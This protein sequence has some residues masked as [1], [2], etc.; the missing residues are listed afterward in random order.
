MVPEADNYGGH[1][2]A[3][4]A[5]MTNLEK[6]FHGNVEQKDANERKRVAAFQ[7][8]MQ[9]KSDEWDQRTNMRKA[10]LQALTTAID[11]VSKR[12]AEQAGK[13]TMKR[14]LQVPAGADVGDSQ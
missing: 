4:L 8:F 10:E 3:Q 13:T 7:G 5:T 6:D 1:S 11:I 12:V 2:D 14:F 9:A